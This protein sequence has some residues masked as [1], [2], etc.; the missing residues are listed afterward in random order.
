MGEDEVGWERGEGKGGGFEAFIS[1]RKEKH[2]LAIGAVEFFERVSGE[3][4]Q[5]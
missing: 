1:S 2:H 5:V 4:Q 3:R